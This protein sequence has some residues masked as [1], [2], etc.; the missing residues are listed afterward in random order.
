MRTTENIIYDFDSLQLH[1]TNKRLNRRIGYQGR[2]LNVLK[3]ERGIL[4]ND[5]HELEYLLERKNQ[6]IKIYTFI[7]LFLFLKFLYEY[8]TSIKIDTT[9]INYFLHIDYRGFARNSFDNFKLMFLKAKD[10]FF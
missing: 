6:I 10:F 8:D 9:H 4:E 1:N 3:V 2:S 5:V 7:M